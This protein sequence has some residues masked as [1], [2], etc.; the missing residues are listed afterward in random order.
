VTGAAAG[1]WLNGWAVVVAAVCGALLVSV[2]AAWAATLT[3]TSSHL[4]GAT[5][6]PFLYPSS[7]AA[8]NNGTTA[9]KV[10][11]GDGFSVSYSEQLQATTVCSVA[12]NTAPSQTLP[13]L[14]V[15]IIDNGAGTGNDEIVY[16]VGSSP[17]PSVHFGAVDLGSPS[18]VTGGSVS[19]PASS[20][21]I[22]QGASSAT[23]AVTLGTPSAGGTLGTVS[24]GSSVLYTPDPTINDK[25]GHDI[26][27]STVA[28][29]TMVQF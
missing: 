17:C 6:T 21:V 5:V 15:Q 11:A 20:A 13:G 25:S 29:S 26:G 23:I 16:Q 19:F 28:T 24:A 4:A 27:T 9:G 18:Y 12:S 1:K 8:T 3:L 2:P 10:Q 7:V 22:T 14:T